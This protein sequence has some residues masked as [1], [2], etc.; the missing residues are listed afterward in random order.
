MNKPS[1][2]IINRVL[3]GLA[4]TTEA[5]L[6]AEWFSTG[7]GQEYLSHRMEG[8]FPSIKEGYEELMTGHEIP[9]DEMFR[10]IIKHIRKK[11]LGRI[12]FRVAAV[13][14]PF[15]LIMG[16]YYRLDSKVDLF[17]KTEYEEFYVPKGERVQF[18]FQD[19][20][21]AYVNSDSKIR[22][23]KQF[24]LSDRTISIRGEAYFEVAPN[25]NR[26]FIVELEKG[27][28]EVLGTSFN[29]DAYPEHKDIRVTLDEGKINLI[30]WTKENNILNPGEMV[31]Y[32][33]ESGH[34]QIVKKDDANKISLWKKDV[35]N[36]SNTPLSEVIERLNKWYDVEFI[37]EDKEVLIHSYTFTSDNT[38][39][40]N[41]LR[42]LEKI[43]P[44][45][46]IYKD[47]AVIVRKK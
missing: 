29:V 36:F 45:R 15:I 23:P 39:L 40:E 3:E 32:N 19:G 42:E 18:M 2:E 24:G 14:L 25:K 20:T 30:P 7:K 1:E 35:I 22:F 43:A 31:I 9:S 16:I 26:P 13:V 8:E 46:F 37:V 5:K 12:L 6:V 21:R 41:V 10:I 27:K 28:I 17:G 47:K 38:L 44:I 11:R 33:K 34:C 4:T